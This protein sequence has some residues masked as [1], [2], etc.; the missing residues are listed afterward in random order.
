MPA[1]PTLFGV[2]VHPHV[3]ASIRRAKSVGGMV[4]FALVL[5]VSQKNGVPFAAACTRAIVGGVL[6]SL[7]AWAVSVAVWRHLLRART[8]NTVA[9]ATQQRP[10]R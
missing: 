8:R 2:S 9:R 6:G 4:G 1:D 5:M 3:T 10:Q 7:V